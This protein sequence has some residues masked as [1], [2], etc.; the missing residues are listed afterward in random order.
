MKT[1]HKLA[2]AFGWYREITKGCPLNVCKT[3][4][5]TYFFEGL[6]EPVPLGKLF[7]ELY[8]WGWR[9]GQQAILPSKSF[10]TEWKVRKDGKRRYRKVAIKTVVNVW[11]TESEPIEDMEMVVLPPPEPVHGQ[12]YGTNTVVTG[13]PDDDELA[14]V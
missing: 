11:R 5:G 12:L 14:V 1:L 2:I 6:C 10:K 8:D 9:D 4:F 7:E 13:Y 3:V